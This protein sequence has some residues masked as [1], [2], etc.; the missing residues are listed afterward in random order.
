M[1]T[2]RVRFTIESRYRHETGDTYGVYVET[3][4]GGYSIPGF[5]GFDSEYEALNALAEALGKLAP[6]KDRPRA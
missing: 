3:D 1:T 2:S 4:R 5:D 6:Q